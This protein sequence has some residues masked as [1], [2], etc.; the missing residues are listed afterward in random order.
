MGTKLQEM[1]ENLINKN[2]IRYYN[3]YCSDTEVHY[4]IVMEEDKIKSLN[5]RLDK[6]GENKLE[7]KFKLIH[8]LMFKIKLHLIKIIRLRNMIL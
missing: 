8:Q 1:L 5:K 7:R 2:E 3:S 6:N 4:E